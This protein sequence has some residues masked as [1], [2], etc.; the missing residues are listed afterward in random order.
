MAIER[1]VEIRVMCDHYDGG[2]GTRCPEGRDD[3]F[4]TI[5]EATYWLRDEGW[6]IGK[7]VLC[8]EHAR[9]RR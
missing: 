2:A 5:G 7:K 1:F 8:P 6:S 9:R 3:Q 4:T